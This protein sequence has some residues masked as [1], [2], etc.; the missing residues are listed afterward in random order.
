[1]QFLFSWV[2]KAPFGYLKKKKREKQKGK[3]KNLQVFFSFPA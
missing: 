2:L 1:M 3:N